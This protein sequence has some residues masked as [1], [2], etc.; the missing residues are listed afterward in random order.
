MKAKSYNDSI[1]TIEIGKDLPELWNDYKIKNK[2]IFSY[3]L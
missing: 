3:Y 2:M 1:F